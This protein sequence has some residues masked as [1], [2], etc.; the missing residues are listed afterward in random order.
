MP[1][2]SV[3]HYLPLHHTAAPALPMLSPPGTM[4]TTTTSPTTTKEQQE[5]RS[6]HIHLVVILV[7]FVVV[8]LW[9]TPASYPHGS[10]F[11]LGR[12]IDKQLQYTKQQPGQP[13]LR[14]AG[15]SAGPLLL[16]DEFPQGLPHP[17]DD[18]VAKSVLLLED[19]FPQGL[20]SPDDDDDDTGGVVP[21]VAK[22]PPLVAH[23]LSVPFYIYPN[24]GLP[25][26]LTIR[27]E[28][29]D[30]RLFD[31]DSGLAT[32]LPKKHADDYYLVKAALD[33]PMR[34]MDPSQAYVLLTCVFYVL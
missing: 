31:R 28:I 20:P 13:L 2:K 16:E 18:N 6:K 29:F 26:T 11:T 19:E 22:E 27:D 32:L 8:G 3:S 10:S 9:S 5:P 25:S 33:H 17:D 34:T 21:A 23:L 30:D 14:A 15:S 12:T 1:S 4:S 7:I 24:L